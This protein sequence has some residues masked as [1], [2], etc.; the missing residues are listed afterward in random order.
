MQRVDKLRFS[1][2]HYIAIVISIS[3][4]AVLV[5]S[6][7]TAVWQLDE[8]ASAASV[9]ATVR[10]EHTIRGSALSGLPNRTV[11][12]RAELIVLRAFPPSALLPGQHIQLEYE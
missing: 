11:L 3:V 4:S 10:V 1:I 9:L 12:G 6:Y 7:P 8:V 5:R 2:W